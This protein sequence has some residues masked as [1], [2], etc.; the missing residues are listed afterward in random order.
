MVSTLKNDV[1]FV[2]NSY[3]SFQTVRLYQDNHQVH[4]TCMYVERLSFF[5]FGVLGPFHLTASGSF[6]RSAAYRQAHEAD[7]CGSSVV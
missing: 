6:T 7:S 2:L 1:L 3:L 4:D 5:T